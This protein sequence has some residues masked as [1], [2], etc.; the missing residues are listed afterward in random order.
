MRVLLDECMPRKIRGEL[1]DHHVQTVTQAG[2]SG[3]KNGALLNLAATR[4]DVFLTVDGSLEYQQNLVTLPIAVIVLTSFRNDLASL[5]P[6]M[7]QVRELLPLV[8]PGHLYH[9]GHL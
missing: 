4:F 6:L 7:P 3:V 9:I 8:Q 5:R 2:W 1:P